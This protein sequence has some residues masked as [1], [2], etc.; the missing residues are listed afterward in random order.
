MTQKQFRLKTFFAEL[1][2]RKV[3]RV[4]TVYTVVGI[5][6]IEIS[7]IIGG[8]FS[9]PDWIIRLIII[10]VICGFFLAVILGWIFDITSKGI[11]RTESLTPQQQESLPSFTWRPSWVSMILLV[12]VIALTVTYCTVPRPN[13]LGFHKQ[14][15][16]LI[17]DLENNTGEEIFDNSLTHALTVAIEQ[18]KYINVYPKSQ[19]PEVL[20]RMRMDS[21]KIISKPVAL[22]IAQRERIKGVL[23]LAISEVGQTYLIITELVDP[24]SGKVIRSRSITVKGKDDI[25]FEMNK[26]A[27]KLR[28]DL[29]E[30]LDEIHL[31]T[32]PLPKAT[33]SSLE[34]LKSMTEGYEAWATGQA[35]EGERLIQEAIKLDPEFAMAHAHLGS[36][37]YWA[38]N[39]EQGDYHFNKA[40]S[41]TDR[42]TEIERMYIEAR[43]ERFRGNYDEAIIRYNIMLKKYPDLPD[44]WFSL[45]YCHMRLENYNEAIAAF[46]R[47]IDIRGENEPNTLI[48]IASCYSNIKKFDQ[49]VKYYLEAFSINPALLTI[50]NLNHEFG[51]T[52]VAM[53]EHQKAKDVFEKMMSGTDSQKAMGLRSM[54]LL[55]LYEGKVSEAI[56]TINES[57]EIYRL[58]GYGLSVLRN[59]L[60]LA[61]MYRTKGLIPEFE[62]ELHDVNEVIDGASSEPFWYLLLG[63]LYARS[64]NIE[65]ARVL[66]DSL[67]GKI[68]EGNRDDEAAFSQLKG[69]IALAEDNQ[70][71]ALQ[72]FEETINLRRD[73]YTLSSLA[74]Y[75]YNTGKLEKA[76]PVYE[77]VIGP[78]YSLGWEA[79]QCCVEAFY[80]LARIYEEMGN[81]EQASKYYSNL[82]DLWENADQDIPILI[83][84]E[85]RLARLE[86]LI[87]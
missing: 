22:E 82:L 11:E 18:S 62:K 19:I 35:P 24:S 12:L 50:P 55:D 15:W 1:K 4:A 29:G 43:V 49:S 70:N 61:V 46:K 45:G 51:F 33:T 87:P 67:S 6:I 30:A 31:R 71:E 26:L 86:T 7:D 53:G 38:N 75:Y 20:R 42:L 85:E 10:L 65:I 32:L 76:I 13:A 54:A 23:S 21:V 9:L 40:L 41:L 39:R 28:K 16:I 77:E 63:K 73:S 74:D 47:A 78:E 69:E 80:K 27:T 68:N 34:A 48:N 14:D 56:E 64:G 72:L 60:L 84:S 5:G 25:L 79:Q 52:Y 3:A 83:D 2:R 57:T 58:L 44:A 17:S 36:L 81:S 8:R 59:D 66:L 37:Y